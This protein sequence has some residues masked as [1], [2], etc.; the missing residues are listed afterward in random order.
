METVHETES[1]IASF[2]TEYSIL[3]CEAKECETI[4]M[5]PLLKVLKLWFETSLKHERK[6]ISSRETTWLMIFKSFSSCRGSIL[7]LFGM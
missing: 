6:P 4:E 2:N 5:E 3:I 1:M 7:K